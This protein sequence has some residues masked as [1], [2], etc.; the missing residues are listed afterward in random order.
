MRIDHLVWT[1]ADLPMTERLLA[2]QGF[3]A[4]GG[5]SQIGHGTCNRIVPLGGGFI[6]LLAIEDVHRPST[7]RSTEGSCARA[8]ASEPG[9]SPSTMSGPTPPASASRHSYSVAGT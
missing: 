8:R 3:A 7:H 9:F 2:D 4:T 6:E 5:G 1:T